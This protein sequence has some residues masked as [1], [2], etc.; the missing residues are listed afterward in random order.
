MAC[1]KIARKKTAC[2]VNCSNKPNSMSLHI[3]CAHYGLKN[4]FFDV[5]AERHALEKDQ[6]MM[7]TSKVNLHGNHV[8][9]ADKLD[10]R[11]LDF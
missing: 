8:L 3:I 7:T 10:L 1:N 6:H 5:C 2:P 11:R 4:S 9:R